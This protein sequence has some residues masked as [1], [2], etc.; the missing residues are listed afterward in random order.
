MNDVSP[1][2]ELCLQMIIL[3]GDAKASFGE[4]IKAATAGN[5]ERYL[6]LYEA[7]VSSLNEAHTQEAKLMAMYGK[8][9]TSVPIDLIMVHA[10]D[11]LTMALSMQEVCDQ[12]FPLIKTVNQLKSILEKE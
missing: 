3:A 4:A 2:Q 10:N 8:D 5:E 1:I 12:I 9:A 11:H 6:E 7:G